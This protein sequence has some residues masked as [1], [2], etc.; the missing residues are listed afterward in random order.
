MYFLPKLT[1]YLSYCVSFV[2][3]KH[4]Q[5][6]SFSYHFI[7]EFECK[8]CMSVVSNFSMKCWTKG[9]FSRLYIN[10]FNE[11]GSKRLFIWL[12]YSKKGERAKGKFRSDWVIRLTPS[13]IHQSFSLIGV[14]KCE[15]GVKKRV[16]ILRL[17]YPCTKLHL[18]HLVP[19]Y[20]LECT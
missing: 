11:S 2:H 6:D 3:D 17:I 19:I 10:L 18:L 12:E 15:Q 5:R 16:S 13:P 8:L 1:S 7:K 9:S 4:F 20:S 14:T